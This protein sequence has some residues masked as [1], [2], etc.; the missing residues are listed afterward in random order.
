MLPTCAFFCQCS[1]SLCFVPNFWISSHVVQWKRCPSFSSLSS[2][3]SPLSCSH[4]VAAASFTWISPVYIT[5]NIPKYCSIENFIKLPFQR[6]LIHLNWSPNKGVMA[7]LFPLLHAVQKFQNVQPSVIQPYPLVGTSNWPDSWFVGSVTS[8]GLKISKGIMLFSLEVV[9]KFMGTEASCELIRICWRTW[10]CGLWGV[11]SVDGLDLV[12]FGALCPV[13]FGFKSS[14]LLD[15]RVSWWQWCVFSWFCF[16][17]S[18]ECF[19]R[20]VIASNTYCL[21]KQTSTKH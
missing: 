5:E 3:S 10:S 8:W 18:D 16:S 1:W 19:S 2:S 13:S 14:Q 17:Q 21:D 11:M 15:Q 7:V 4:H 6:V 9:Q 20:N 12:V